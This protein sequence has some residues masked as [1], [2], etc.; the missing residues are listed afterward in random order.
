MFVCVPLYIVYIDIYIVY[1]DICSLPSSTGNSS[2]PNSTNAMAAWRTQRCSYFLDGSLCRRRRDNGEL[3]RSY[4]TVKAKVGCICIVYH[5]CCIS[6]VKGLPEEQRATAT[7]RSAVTWKSRRVSSSSVHQ[8]L[9]M[10]I[11]ALLDSINVSFTSKWLKNKIRLSTNSVKEKLFTSV[12]HVSPFLVIQF[13]IRNFYFI[14]WSFS[15]SV[16]LRNTMQNDLK[17]VLV[18]FEPRS[19]PKRGRRSVYRFSRA[20]DTRLY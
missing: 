20:T 1:I 11:S 12:I 15:R 3:C 17:I 2:V 19:R 8:A 5:R 18:I 7:R 14:I 10:A 13:N 6:D 16:V 9:H 4:A